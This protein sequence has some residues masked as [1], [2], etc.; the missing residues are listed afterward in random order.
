MVGF[1]DVAEENRANDASSTPHECDARVVEFPTIVMGCGT[2]EHE[3]LG[4]GDYFGG[5]QCLY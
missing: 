4:I 3:S 2:H 1:G 5:I